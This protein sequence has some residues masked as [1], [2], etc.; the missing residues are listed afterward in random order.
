MAT[1]PTPV[2][3]SPPAN[4]VSGVDGSAPVK[5]RNMTD[6]PSYRLRSAI[7]LHIRKASG[8]AP[9]TAQ[10]NLESLLAYARSI[11]C[12]IPAGCDALEGDDGGEE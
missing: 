11:K 7:R 2:K 8:F 4:R 1:N 3:N 10:V 9:S 6:G 5:R 12:P